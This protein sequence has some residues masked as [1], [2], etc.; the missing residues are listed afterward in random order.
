MKL[1]I[2]HIDLKQLATLDE[3]Y[4][5]VFV[6]YM[7]LLLNRYYPLLLIDLLLVLLLYNFFYSIHN[8]HH[9]D[10]Y[11]DEYTK[12]IKLKLINKFNLIK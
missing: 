5:D 4:N 8:I 9:K 10:Q 1:M 3:V 6:D 11:N 12:K 2:V 7:L